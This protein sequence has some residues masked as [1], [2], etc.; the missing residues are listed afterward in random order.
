[1]ADDDR[2]GDEARTILR[3]ATVADLKADAAELTKIIEAMQRPIPVMPSDPAEREVALVVQVLRERD[4]CRRLL[5]LVA[6]G[7]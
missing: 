3:Y 7:S 1:M 4:R 5:A 2:L 6:S